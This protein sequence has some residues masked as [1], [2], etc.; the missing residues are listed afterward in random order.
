MGELIDLQDT[1]MAKEEAVRIL[2]ESAFFNSLDEKQQK[3]FL[4]LNKTRWYYGDNFNIIIY[5]FHFWSSSFL[6][7]SLDSPSFFF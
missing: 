2:L 4:Q 7:V 6:G 1:K 3:E 5:T